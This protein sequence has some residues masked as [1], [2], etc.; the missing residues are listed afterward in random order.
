MTLLDSRG[1]TVSTHSR[2]ALQQYEQA[3]ELSAGYYVDPMATIRVALDA[4][5]DFAMGHCLR[6]ALVV[7]STDRSMVPMLGASVEAAEAI[8]RRANDRERMHAAAARKWLQGDFAASVRAYGDIV[9]EYPR[10][11]LALQVAHV[12]DFLM[13]SSTMLRDR[14]AHVLPYW[15]NSVPG[16]GFVLGMHAFG[17]EECAAYSQAEDTGR[18]ALAIN[19]RDPWAVHA[20]AHVMEMTGRVREG[21]DWLTSR[22]DHW[23][24][25]NGFAFHNWWHLALYYLDTGDVGRVFELFDRRIRP[26]ASAVPMEMIDAS[27]LLWRLHLRDIDVGPRWL[28]L[29]QSWEAFAEQAYYAF[30]DVHAVMAFVGAGRFDLA[31]RTIAALERKATGTDTNAMMSRD[32]GLPLA[33]ALLAFGMDR[34]NDVINLLAPVR[35][36]AHRFGGSHAQRDLVHLTLVEAALRSGNARLARALAAERT[37]LK[38]AS[39]CN[40][41]LTARALDLAGDSMGAVKA[42]EKAE[43]RRKVQ[44]GLR[45]V[46]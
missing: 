4:D 19:P 37:Q 29:A 42:H 15:D 46:A 6:A 7:M 36:I 24:H 23:A 16:Y 14:I 8:G 25:D 26:V 41:Q 38:P 11:L 9:V 5:P 45:Q 32:V 44:L 20:V 28:E 18:R 17:L 2:E 40:W 35:T 13:G 1:M 3:V 12:G 22:E 34:Y 39:P 10:D 43:I 21:I 27:A 33:Q 30:N 31:Q